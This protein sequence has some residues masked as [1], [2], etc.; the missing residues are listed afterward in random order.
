MDRCLSC[1]FPG[2][3]S[4]SGD[5]HVGDLL[6]LCQDINSFRF[7][8]LCNLSNAFFLGTSTFHRK[9]CHNLPLALHLPLLLRSIRRIAIANF[10]NFIFTTLSR[11]IKCVLDHS[12]LTLFSTSVCRIIT[13]LSNELPKPDTTHPDS[14]LGTA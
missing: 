1:V 5:G 8:I 9:I 3:H 7:M 11:P 12:I 10:A 6:R 4:L 2:K 14:Q 13:A